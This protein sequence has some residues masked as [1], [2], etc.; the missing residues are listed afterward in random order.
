MNEILVLAYANEDLLHEN[1]FCYPDGIVC[2]KNSTLVIFCMD[3][4]STLSI[5]V[6]HLFVL[7]KYIIA[8]Y[9]LLKTF[10]QIELE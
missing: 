9:M 3:A 2:L 6:L 1:A 4:I 7:V 5:F 8:S 10:H